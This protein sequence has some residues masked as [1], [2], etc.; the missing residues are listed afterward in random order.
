M[1]YNE[2]D[3]PDPYTFKPER[4][5]KNGRLNEEIKNPEDIAFG[6]GRR[7]CP[8]RHIALST[9]WLSIASILSTFEIEKPVDKNGHIVEPTYEIVDLG[10]I[11][12]KPFSCSFKPRSDEAVSLIRS[13]HT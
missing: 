11:H 13:L 1:L 7:K 6:F 12:P 2:R 5:L 3:Y 8:G 10:I 4:F 9:L